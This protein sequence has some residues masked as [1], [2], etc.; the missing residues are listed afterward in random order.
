MENTMTLKNLLI[1]SLTALVLTAPSWAHAADTAT[2]STT[3]TR[4]RFSDEIVGTGP[5]LIFIPGLA[6]SR[7]T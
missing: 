4:D 1:G 7:D 3:V 6:S 5:D 2:A